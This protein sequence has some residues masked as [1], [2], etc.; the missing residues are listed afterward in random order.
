MILR[1]VFLLGPKRGP[2]FNTGTTELEENCLPDP[3]DST[4]LF[5][6][7]WSS[8]PHLLS[9]PGKSLVPTKSLRSSG[10]LYA[11]RLLPF[12]DL[13]CHLTVSVFS[14]PNSVPFYQD[15]NCSGL[16][17]PVIPC[18]YLVHLHG[19]G[20]CLQSELNSLTF[21]LCHANFWALNPQ[22]FPYSST[23]KLSVYSSSISPQ[24]AMCFDT[25]TSANAI[26]CFHPICRIVHIYLAVITI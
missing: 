11:F 13:H 18:F 9:P 7:T 21:K 22:D 4:R 12:P 26:I 14:L 17:A 15:E 3:R 16:R 5:P 23:T 2:K 19:L 10:A 8:F 20:A 1:T 6:S 25:F 24:R